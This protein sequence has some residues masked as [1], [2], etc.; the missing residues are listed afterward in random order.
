MKVLE[1]A[2]LIEKNKNLKCTEE[3]RKVLV[4][5]LDEALNKKY[6]AV[7]LNIGGMLDTEDNLNERN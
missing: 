5:K 4:Q 6:H 3:E 1:Y 2:L 7:C